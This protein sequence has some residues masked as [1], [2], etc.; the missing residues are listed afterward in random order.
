VK[1]NHSLCH[2]GFTWQIKVETDFSR[3]ARRLHASIDHAEFSASIV[4][5]FRGFGRQL[6]SGGEISGGE[7][8]QTGLAPR[9]TGAAGKFP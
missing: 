6:S 8:T 3:V 7:A 1:G 5:L 4:K 2:Q 9:L